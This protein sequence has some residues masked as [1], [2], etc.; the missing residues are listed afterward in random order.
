M[1]VVPYSSKFFGKKNLPLSSVHGRTL[2]N[3][4]MDSGGSKQRHRMSILGQ[5]R[6]LVV[7]VGKVCSNNLIRIVSACRYTL[8]NRVLLDTCCCRN[9][10]NHPVAGKCAGSADTRCPRLSFTH[11]SLL[12]C[13]SYILRGLKV[14][15]NIPLT[16]GTMVS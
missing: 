13:A 8:A 1:A 10:H 3:I 11:I 9:R 4:A 5:Y 12:Q 16:C 2:L 6:H 7:L 14:P 15:S